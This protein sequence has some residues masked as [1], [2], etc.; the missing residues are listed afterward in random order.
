M[1]QRDGL[2]AVIIE[3]SSSDSLLNLLPGGDSGDKTEGSQDRLA[4]NASS[5]TVSSKSNSSSD[6]CR[7]GEE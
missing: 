6:S 5:T 2:V 1:S 3:S 4:N 7:G